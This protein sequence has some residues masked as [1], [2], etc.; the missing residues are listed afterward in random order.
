MKSKIKKKKLNIFQF[1][2]INILEY[3]KYIRIIKKK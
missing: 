2:L 1:I 3:L